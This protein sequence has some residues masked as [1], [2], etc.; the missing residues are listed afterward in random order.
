[1]K[2]ALADRM[3]EA[4][5]A[6]SATLPGA[7]SKRIAR[8]R[9]EAISRFKAQ[10]L[11]RMSDEAW[12]YTNLRSLEKHAFEPARRA[13]SAANVRLDEAAQ[14]GS[15][16]MVFVDGWLDEERSCLD[17]LPDGVSLVSLN[18][19][20]ADPDGAPDDWQAGQVLEALGALAASPQ[21]GFEALNAAFAADGAIVCLSDNVEVEKPIELVFAS[22]DDA[23]GALCNTCN[24]LFAGENSS[25]TIIER[26]VSSALTDH[27]TVASFAAFVGEGARVE[28]CRIQEENQQAFHVGSTRVIQHAHSS[29]KLHAHTL[30]A[31]LSRHDVTQELAS[32]H[33]N[34]E[35]NGLYVG[36]RSQHMDHYT[37]IVH[38]SCDA[39]SSEYYKGVMDDRSRAVFHGRIRVEK[40]AQRTDARQQNRNLLLSRNAEADT[41]P[42][43]EIY[44]DDVKCAHGATIGQLDED[45]VY[46][47]QTRGFDEERARSMLTDAF[48]SE[49]VELI[50][51]AP[52]REYVGRQVSDKLHRGDHGGRRA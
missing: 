7:S 10:R 44:A 35:L 28:H 14:F 19:L 31:S 1:M 21:H 46:Y 52:V 20:M 26:H 45:A 11:P 5:D 18:A 48:A 36:Q 6:A 50:G 42:Q 37:T 30:G 2:S 40:D 9:A 25:A 4:Y 22:S 38:S 33:S 13:N 24:F 32:A 39:S 47:L 3:A 23:G 49:I 16:R 12:R 27:L 34:C 51:S 15:H 29:Y 41:K 8:I 43:L 17:Q